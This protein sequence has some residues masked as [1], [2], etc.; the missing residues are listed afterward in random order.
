MDLTYLRSNLE[1]NCILTF[2][3]CGKVQKRAAEGFD[4]TAVETSG[5]DE[6]LSLLEYITQKSV[7]L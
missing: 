2:A 1:T 5:N 3:N 7:K 6:N 4:T